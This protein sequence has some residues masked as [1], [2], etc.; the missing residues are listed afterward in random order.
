VNGS[1]LDADRDYSDGYQRGILFSPSRRRIRRCTEAT[2]AAAG[3]R[4]G[5]AAALFLSSAKWKHIRLRKAALRQVA[6]IWFMLI[7]VCCWLALGTEMS[8]NVLDSRLLATG[9]FR[10]PF[11]TL[12][13][14]LVRS[15]PG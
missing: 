15:A 5:A 6:S 3:R 8:A 12:F 9:Q 13:A 7:P 11:V 2:L 10:H 14:G 1:R 4:V